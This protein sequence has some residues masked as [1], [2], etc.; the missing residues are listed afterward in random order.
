LHLYQ[1]SGFNHDE[2]QDKDA[3]G[4]DLSSTDEDTNVNDVAHGTSKENIKVTNRPSDRIADHHHILNSN[5]R[6][7]KNQKV[8]EIKDKILMAKA[9]L[10][11][12]PPSSNSH[13]KEL[14]LQMKEMEQAV[15]GATRDSD[16]SRR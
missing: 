10:K 11:F 1:F 5:S 2:R 8:Q 9:Y 15:E 4:K 14:E 16:L 7:V 3:Q 6:E 13:L 12:A